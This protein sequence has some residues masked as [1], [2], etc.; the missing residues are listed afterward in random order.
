MKNIKSF[1]LVLMGL[2]SLPLQAADLSLKSPNGK[3]SVEIGTDGQLSYSIRHNGQVLLD[4]SPIGL[5]L[6]DKVLGENVKVS[7]TGRRMSIK[8]SIVSPNY[9]CASFDVVYNELNLKLKGNSGVIFRAYDEGIAYRFYTSMQ[10]SLVI[11]NE[12]IRMNF[13]QDYTTYMAYSTAKPE[14]DPYAMAF[15]NLYTQSTVKEARTDNIAFLPITV[16]CGNE[17]KMTLLESDLENY[18]GMFVQGV[19]GRTSLQGNFAKYPA[20]MKQFPP[21]A[22]ERVVER[23]DY[24]AQTAGKRNFPWRI[25]AITEK[26]TEMP[27]NN[28]VY[29]LASPNRIGDVSWIKTGK[30]AWD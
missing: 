11:Q 8:E 12:I 6:D 7:R 29:A 19:E 3:L 28:L 14:K 2:I 24:I 18:P 22:M 10:D 17:L 13:P 25:W 26:D 27:V 16:D 15:Q 20:Q 30:V 21:R 9:R 1:C 5:V 4:K 23:T